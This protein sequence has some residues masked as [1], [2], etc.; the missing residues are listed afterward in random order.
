[1]A[2]CGPTHHLAC[3]CVQEAFDRLAEA[4]PDLIVAADKRRNDEIGYEEW[5]IAREEAERALAEWR[6]IRGRG[7]ETGGIR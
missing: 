3:P 4:A 1:M 7:T 2:D 6:A 5:K